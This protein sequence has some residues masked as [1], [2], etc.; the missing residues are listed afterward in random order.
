MEILSIK[1]LWWGN[2]LAS[3]MTFFA[4]AAWICYDKVRKMES[5][6]KGC[7]SMYTIRVRMRKLG[8]KNRDT[9]APVAYELPAKPATVRELIEELTV[10]GVAAY[11]ARKDEGQIVPHLTKQEIEDKAGFGK[12][13]FGLRGGNDADPEAAVKNALQCFEDGIFRVFADDEELERLDQAIPWK[14][15]PVFT[16]VRLTMLAGW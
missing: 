8:K 13:A 15:E 14:E 9:I 1:I 6:T 2:A 5:I 12:V 16:F 7:E 4:F 11:N 10:Q 3:A